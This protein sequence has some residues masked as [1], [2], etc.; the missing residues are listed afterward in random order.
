M[1][2]R[3]TNP[4]TEEDA[5]LAQIRAGRVSPDVRRE[6]SRNTSMRAWLINNDALAAERREQRRQ[7]ETPASQADILKLKQT[8]EGQR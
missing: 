4:V 7:R 8:L 2:K 6:Q 5:I 1:P 3:Q